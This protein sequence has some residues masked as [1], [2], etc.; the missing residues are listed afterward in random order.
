MLFFRWND[1]WKDTPV[2]QNEYEKLVE[3]FKSKCLSDISAIEHKI[4]CDSDRIQPRTGGKTDQTSTKEKMADLTRKTRQKYGLDSFCFDELFETKARSKK[5]IDNLAEKIAA[6][7]RRSLL[8]PANKSTVLENACCNLQNKANDGFVKHN[9][10][11]GRKSTPSKPKKTQRNDQYC[12]RNDMSEFVSQ[13]EQSNIHE[14]ETFN[15]SVD[16]WEAFTGESMA[17]NQQQVD[18]KEETESVCSDSSSLSS[19]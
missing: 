3:T 11:R 12:I 8:S 7:H 5:S 19:K 14:K 2:V 17:L 4:S 15:L 16:F 18:N 6:D 1:F 10:I 13:I 9:I